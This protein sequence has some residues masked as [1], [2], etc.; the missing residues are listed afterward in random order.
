MKSAGYGN[1]ESHKKLHD[2]F[3]EKLGGSFPLNDGSIN[4]AK[5]WLVNHIKDIDFG[6]KGKL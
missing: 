6:Y 2:A 5:D 4:F 3:V 1:Y